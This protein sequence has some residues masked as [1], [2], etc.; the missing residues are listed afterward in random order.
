MHMY[1][2]ISYKIVTFP[3]VVIEI[4][5]VFFKPLPLSFNVA[6]RVF[7]KEFTCLVLIALGFACVIV[8]VSN[9]MCGSIMFCV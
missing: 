2:Q 1:V 5:R 3:C 9:S 6:L 4:L 7:A 8:Y